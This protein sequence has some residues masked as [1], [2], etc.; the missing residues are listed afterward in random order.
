M[1][2]QVGVARDMADSLAIQVPAMQ[3]MALGPVILDE[4]LFMRFIELLTTLQDASR[5][6]PLFQMYRTHLE[7]RKLVLVSLSTT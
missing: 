7:K 4:G 2:M 6:R 5:V 1:H 3:G